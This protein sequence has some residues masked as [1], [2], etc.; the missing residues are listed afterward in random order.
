MI[1]LLGALG[2]FA[3]II[4]V[5]IKNE[6]TTNRHQLLTNIPASIALGAVITVLPGGLVYVVTDEVLVTALGALVSGFVIAW[7]IEALDH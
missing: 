7:L 4:T 6:R 1:V 3:G 2:T 5:I